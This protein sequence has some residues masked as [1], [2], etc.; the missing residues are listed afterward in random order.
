MKTAVHLI[1]ALALLLS[2]GCS[3][4]VPQ[5]NP[6]GE[7][8]RIKPDYTGITIPC[9]IAPLNFEV[10][11][12]A[13]VVLTEISFPSGKIMTVR[14]ADVSFP[15]SRWHALLSSAPGDVML[16][17]FVRRNGSWTALEPFKWHVSKDETDPYISYRL[18]EP[19]YAMAGD[20]AVCQ[21]SLTD[22]RWKEIFS[23]K[24]DVGRDARQCI[25]CHSY[26]AYRTS[27]MQFHVRQKD[28]GTIIIRDGKPVK[29]NLKADGLLSAGVYPSWHPSEPL[30]AYSLNSTKQYFFASGHQK[31]EV[32]DSYSD[33][34]L[35]DAESNTETVISDDKDDLE[36]FP[37]W[38]PDGRSLYYCCASTTDVHRT[39][40]S[41]LISGDYESVR[42]DILKRDFDISSRSFSTPDTVL[43]ASALGFSA[44]F[45]RQCPTGPY[46]LFTMAPFGNFH[47]WHSDAD[48]YLKN[49]ETGEV[50]PADEINSEAV[51]SYHSWSSNGRWV[52]FSS[53]RDDG[54]Y[55]RLYLSHFDGEGGFSKPFVLPQKSPR[56]GDALFKSYNLPEFMLEEVPYSP[57]ELIRTVRSES[58]TAIL[59]K[60]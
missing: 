41:S 24:L 49:L 28:G 55:T 22:F 56:S 42:Y 1:A 30:I 4:R 3:N 8:A 50:R 14:G 39:A 59:S 10:L 37:Y 23:N 36:T 58:T 21:R 43:N 34:I 19:T 53:R 45:P 35:Y 29:V 48:L 44:T 27:N 54:A 17:V 46:L 6:C 52:V 38:S 5:V 13:D 15:V 51:E 25:N 40:K 11:N 31:A 57:K 7:V 12:D 60:D 33:I 18:I 20:M 47:I 9:N 32:I 2:A 26:Q 16:R